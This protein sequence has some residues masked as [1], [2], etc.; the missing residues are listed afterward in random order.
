MQ[1]Q[2]FLFLTPKFLCTDDKGYKYLCDEKI[3]CK[4]LNNLQIA[5]N[6]P[7]TLVVHFSLYCDRNYLIAICQ[8]SFFICANICTLIFSFVADLKGRIITILFNYVLGVLPLLAAPFS[9]NWTMFII[10]LS[11]SG[12]GLNAYST[13]CFVLLSESSGKLNF[14]YS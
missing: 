14:I 4:N 8:T 3:A 1:G 2:P 12:A 11:I 6:Q 7:N 9:T 5:P 10:M 13:L